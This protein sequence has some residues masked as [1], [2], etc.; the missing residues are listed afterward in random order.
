MKTCSIKDCCNPLLAKGLCR[1]HYL[2]QYKHGDP[3][4][5]KK[6]SDYAKRGINAPQ[7]KH[8]L[9][10]HPL[11]KTWS[12]MM[13]RCYSEK[14]R[15]YKNYGGRGIYVCEQWHDLR[16]FVK[17]MGDRPNGCSLDRINNDLGYSPENC[18]WATDEMQS[19]NRRHAKLTIEKAESMR[20]M[21]KSFQVTRKELALRFEVSEATV[22][23]VL[24]GAYWK[25]S[26]VEKIAPA[27]AGAL[28]R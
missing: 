19:R 15:A 13:R 27:V 3:M 16:V 5:V 4:A 11:Y 20:E 25:P 7:F 21:R 24:S 2:R 6:P 8:G 23:K 18:R 26:Q 22:K 17:D 14:E 28:K 1:K 9:W 12:N 10:D